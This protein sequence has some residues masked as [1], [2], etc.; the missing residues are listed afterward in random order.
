M[1]PSCLTTP[2]DSDQVLHCIKSV[3]H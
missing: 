3:G 2:R 1:A